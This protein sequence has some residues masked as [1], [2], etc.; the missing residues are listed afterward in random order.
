MFKL[1]TLAALGILSG[2]IAAQASP[3][4]QPTHTPPAYTI[5]VIPLPPGFNSL[6]VSGINN[7]G[8]A[9]GFAFDD[10][11][12]PRFASE[13]VLYHN[14]KLINLAPFL[15]PSTSSY[16]FKINDFGEII[17]EYTGGVDDG[18]FI[19][20]NGHVQLFPATLNTNTT[21][22]TAFEDINDLGQIVGQEYVNGSSSTVFLR[23]PNGAMVTILPP[24]SSFG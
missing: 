19:Y 13:A 6:E 16:A 24:C 8:D 15:P 9:V 5:T 7:E 22:T 21:I 17:G 1:R 14:G 4:P 10:S 2:A 23:Q 3:I 20:Q 11:S 18:Y 12:P